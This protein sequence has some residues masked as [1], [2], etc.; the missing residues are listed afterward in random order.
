[1]K[2]LTITRY[3]FMPY[4]DGYFQEG[5]F[6]SK[7][8]KIIKQKSYNG[9]LCIQYKLKRYGIVKLRKFA[10]RKE[11]AEDILPF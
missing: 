10:K 11:V 8:G 4:F 5:N 2:E 3:T 6:Y 9:C 7:D 1:M